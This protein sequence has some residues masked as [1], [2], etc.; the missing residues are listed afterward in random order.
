[1]HTTDQE[2]RGLD[3]R[4]G[5]P[6]IA[7]VYVSVTLHMLAV[8]MAGG[9]EQIP[10][11]V[12]GTCQLV[13]GLAAL[14]LVPQWRQRLRELLRTPTQL[15]LLFQAYLLTVA[16]LSLCVALPYLFGHAASPLDADLVSRYP[17]RAFVPP[18]LYQPAAYLAF[19]VLLGPLLHLVNAAGEEVFWRGYLLDWLE[20]RRSRNVAWL[21]NGL[22]WGLWHAP[23]IVLLGWD[24]P[25][26]PVF[27]V[28]VI[29]GSQ[30]FWSI[31]LCYGTRK[32]GRLWL[33][34]VMHATANALTIGL[35]DLAV[36]D[37]WNLFYSPWGLLGGAVMA[38]VSLAIFMRTLR[39]PSLQ[40]AME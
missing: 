9:L 20:A 11:I 29:T 5:S 4:T 37:R 10:L 38:L 18:T 6:V 24:F 17:L 34:I 28:F 3:A 16:T 27:G 36:D 32:T 25:G 35:F 14:L 19:V 21:L 22:L 15:G 30:V 8:R 23:M 7:V 1:M 33:A 26:H 40:G 39:W 13:P 31:V 12:F 2:A